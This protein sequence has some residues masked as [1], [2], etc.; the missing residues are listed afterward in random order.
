MLEMSCGWSFIKLLNDNGT[1]IANKAY[2]LPVNGGSPFE[3]GVPLDRGSNL[4]LAASKFSLSSKSKGPPMISIK[5]ISP[6]K[7]QTRYIE[8]LPEPIVGPTCH[9]E[10]FFY[11]RHIM[12]DVQ[13]RF[14]TNLHSTDPVHSPL[15]SSFLDAAE[16]AELMD[17]FTKS[18]IQL[19]RTFTFVFME[20]VYPLLHICHLDSLPPY[21]VTHYK[22][23]QEQ[24]LFA[25]TAT[26]VLPSSL[27]TTTTTAKGTS[28]SKQRLAGIDL[29][30]SPFV[31]YEPFDTQELI[32][33]PVDERLILNY[34]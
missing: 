3:K 9:L 11:L 6:S 17:V 19:K 33:N 4:S 24:V 10:Y 34:F 30:T 2:R 14:K 16:R 1:L 27:P 25:L 31:L 8:C 12:L 32:F 26:T 15:L 29:L 13:V 20:S 7:T 18:L 21:D 22:A 28:N 5:M 23:R